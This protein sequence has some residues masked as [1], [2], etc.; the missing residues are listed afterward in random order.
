MEISVLSVIRFVNFSSLL[1]TG[2][3]PCIALLELVTLQI[4]YKSFNFSNKNV[5]AGKNPSISVTG[6]ILAELTVMQESMDSLRQ[7][8][9]FI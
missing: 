2:I 4:D 6:L 8:I 3:L 7:L 9:I 5:Y 1:N